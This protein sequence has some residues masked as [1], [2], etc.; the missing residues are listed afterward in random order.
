M[1]SVLLAVDNSEPSGWQR[2]RGRAETPPAP[3][4]E[5]P[6]EP[7]GT[8]APELPVARA[9]V[10]S[11]DAII[12]LREDAPPSWHAAE[13][14]PS[15]LDEPELHPPEPSAAVDHGEPSARADRR[16]RGSWVVA[17][18]VI[19]VLVAGLVG[20]GLHQRSAA[21]D[22]EARANAAH[23]R[24]QTL[25]RQLTAAKR[26]SAEQ[27][28]LAQANQRLAASEA[29]RAQAALHAADTRPLA[30]RIPSVTDGLRQC[31][32]AALATASD[33]IGFAS[34]YPHASTTAVTADA[35]AVTSICAAANA[36]AT[37]LDGQ[38]VGAR[39]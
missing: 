2:V 14:P 5:T 10:A 29:Q 7:Q 23:A 12:D 38:A 11:D 26:L 37:A 19:V 6:S 27:A 15:A 39:H 35:S 30:S 4:P 33:A 24:V 22:A 13:H 28:H 31:A 1:R 20:Y 9:E 17:V 34:A 8:E 36:A 3:I 16:R 25:D 21:A 32:S 18:A